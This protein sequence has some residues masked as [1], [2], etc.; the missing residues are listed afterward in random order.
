MLLG[1]PL[2]GDTLLDDI[3][4]LLVKGIT[5]RGELNKFETANVL[6]AITKYLKKKPSR[7]SAPFTLTWVKKLHAEMLGEVWGHA[8]QFRTRNPNIGI[9]WEQV[10]VQVENLLRNLEVWQGPCEELSAMLHHRAVQIH[11]F[12]DGNGRWSRLLTN[13]WLKQNGHRIIHWPTTIVQFRSTIRG[14]YVACL[15][16]ADNG[17]LNSLIELHKRYMAIPPGAALESQST[18]S[19]TDSEMS[20]ASPTN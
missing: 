19:Y 6:S 2:D 5:T 14:E 20:K 17:R 9:P 12:K 10:E 15:R 3:S 1:D 16:H 4:E 7:R 13:I 11:P 8:G 18:A